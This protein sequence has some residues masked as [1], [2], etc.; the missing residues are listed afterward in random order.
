M[1]SVRARNGRALLALAL[2]LVALFPSLLPLPAG[3]E[4]AKAK[5]YEAPYKAG[6]QGGDFAN[7]IHADPETGEIAI[8]R[9]FPGIPPVV[10][11]EPE[12]SA[13]WAMFR[14][15]HK[16]TDPVGRITANFN[17]ALDPYAWATVGARNA[18]GDWLGVNKLQ[19]PHVGDGKVTAKL[20]DRPAPGQTITIEFGLQLGDACPQ[21]GAAAATFE[22]IKV[23]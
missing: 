18:S 2:V 9:T 20:F 8:L 17:G 10:G 21:L 11:C 1:R 3:A 19:G 6:P 15:K 22:S 5:T 14:V 23:D 4:K 12:P 7:F 16:V 13:G